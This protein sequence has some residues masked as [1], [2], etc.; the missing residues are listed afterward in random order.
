LISKSNETNQ[1]AQQ[2]IR[3]RTDEETHDCR[4]L[5]MARKIVCIVQSVLFNN[6]VK[7]Y[8]ALAIVKGKERCGMYE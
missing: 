8:I 7:D 6:A 3:Q 2:H 1:N 5:L 4:M